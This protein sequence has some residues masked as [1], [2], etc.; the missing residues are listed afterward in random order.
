MVLAASF[1]HISGVHFNPAVT[2]GV[3]IAGE[4]QAVMTILYV[5]MQLLGG[6]KFSNRILFFFKN[7]FSGIAAGG[8]LNL[9][10]PNPTY[11][12]C[13]GGATLLTHYAAYNGT[14][15]D[16]VLVQYPASSI[17]IWQVCIRK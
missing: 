5:V 17:N 2:I 15:P 11:Q 14:G 1:G 8:I 12:A 16:G 6:K 7:C 4:I 3:L 13:K 9:L 10:L